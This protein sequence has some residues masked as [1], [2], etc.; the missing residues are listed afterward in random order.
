MTI[1][2]TLVGETIVDAKFQ[3]YPCPASSACGTFVTTWAEGKKL[4]DIPS[5]TEDILIAATG[6]MPL[7]REHCPKLAVDAIKDALVR[8]EKLRSESAEVAQ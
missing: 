7:G 1:V 6:P 4:S 8:L 5:L 2:L 3:T